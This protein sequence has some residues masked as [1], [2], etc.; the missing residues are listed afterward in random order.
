MLARVVYENPNSH[1]QQFRNKYIRIKEL[2]RLSVN[3]PCI[4]GKLPP[5][6]LL[7]RC[8]FVKLENGNK[9]VVASFHCISCVSKW[10]VWT[11][12]NVISKNSISKLGGT[13][14]AYLY[15]KATEMRVG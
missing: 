2:I 3:L 5:K 1:C 14:E 12:K 15:L 7:P 8:G 4:L 6:F 13:R 9:E 11:F 10:P